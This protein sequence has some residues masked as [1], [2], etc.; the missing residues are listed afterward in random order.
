MLASLFTIFSCPIIVRGT[1]PQDYSSWVKLH[2][3]HVHWVQDINKLRRRTRTGI[4]LWLTDRPTDFLSR[5]ILEKC[6]FPQLVKMFPFLWKL[7][8][9]YCIH[10]SPSFLLVLSQ[11]DPV[12]S[13]P[14]YWRS[15]HYSPSIY[16][17]VL[18]VLTSFHV[19]LP[20]HCAL[21]PR[22]CHVPLPP[23]PPFVHPNSV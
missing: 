12:H 9:H 20:K 23:Y 2:T 3:T 7:M 8:V 19:S 16:A 10:T 13:L 14:F 5:T 17:C 4:Q 22:S 11:V 21:L 18:Q 1:F 15:F 6:T